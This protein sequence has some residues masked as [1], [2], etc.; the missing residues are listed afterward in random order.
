MC[1]SDMAATAI[2]GKKPRYLIHKNTLPAQSKKTKQ[3][4]SDICAWGLMSFHDQQIIQSG[5]DLRAVT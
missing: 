3:S 4:S 5:D 1:T 2:T